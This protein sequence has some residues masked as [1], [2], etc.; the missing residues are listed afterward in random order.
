M[1]YYLLLV[2]IIWNIHTSC[3]AQKKQNISIDLQSTVELD[4]I[5]YFQ[6]TANKINTRNEGTLVLKGTINFD[7]EA[8]FKTVIE[9]RKDLQDDYRDRL[10]YVREAYFHF[11]DRKIDIKVGKQIVNWG[12]A[13]MYN[14][15]NNINPIDYTDFFELE[16]NQLGVWLISA[17]RF[18][19]DNKFT[20]ILVSPALPTLAV[21]NPDSRWVLGLPQQMLNPLDVE[22]MLPIIYGYDNLQP[23]YKDVGFMA[24][25][26]NGISANNWDISKSIL[27]GA[28][29]TPAF[30]NT[31][32]G[33]DTTG[34]QVRLAP[35]YQRLYALGFDFATTFKYFGLRGE[36][37]L[38]GLSEP[39][40]KQG[41]ATLYYEYTIGI[42]RTFS[43]LIFNKNVMVIL[44]WVRQRILREQTPMANNIRFFLQKSLLL[45]T[46]LAINYYSSFAIQTL[47]TLDAK[48]VYIRPSLKYRILDGLTVIA[49]ADLLF[50]KS[51]G[52]LGQYLGNDRWQVRLSYD[53]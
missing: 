11:V 23:R 42:D 34:V 45:R 24:A 33:I 26:R 16:D 48:N 7:E 8:S 41:L 9:S 46:E 12:T 22:K 19:K 53:F 15:N 25:F 10:A 30:A 52:F 49:Q 6:K 21:P 32:K 14:P 29:Y 17:K 37:A 18:H 1:K 36:L 31:V 35:I 51:N 4:H 38:K 2:A 50:G 20:E 5:S 28:N 40:S 43:Q 3:F 27:V 47:Y 13:D 39:N 44:Q